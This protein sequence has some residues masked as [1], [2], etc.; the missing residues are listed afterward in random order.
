MQPKH[1]SAS[2]S[3]MPPAAQSCSAAV[4]EHAGAPL[5]AGGIGAQYEGTAGGLAMHVPTPPQLFMNLA[6]KKPAAQGVA[7]DDMLGS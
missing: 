3:H 2:P 4:H 5:Q 1:Q 7:S 6:S